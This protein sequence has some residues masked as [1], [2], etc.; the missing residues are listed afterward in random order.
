MQPTKPNLLIIGAR[1]A[2]TTLLYETLGRHPDVWFPKKKE[3][4][5]FTNKTYG[6]RRAW[7]QYLKLFET[8]PSS[9]KIVGEASTGYTTL[10]YNGPTP[11]RIRESLGQPKLIY[12][13]RDPVA[14]TVSNYRHN[15]T[16]GRYRPGTTLT[17]AVERNPI[18]IKASCYA[19]QL[20]A[21]RRIFSEHG[22]LVLLAEEL[23]ACP[24][25]VMARVEHYLQLKPY[26]KWDNDLPKVNPF[27]QLAGAFAVQR[28]LGDGWLAQIGKRIMPRALKHWLKSKVPAPSHLPEVTDADRDVVFDAIAPDLKQLF[29]LIG[30]RLYIWPSVQRLA[31]YDESIAELVSATGPEVD[32]SANYNSEKVKTN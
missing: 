13:L 16:S 19:F 4:H 18:L 8:A 5:Y 7:A 11:E 22:V 2:S 32:D 26:G 12:I 25:E 28:V 23:H 20:K 29:A 17:E 3:P 1:K 9:A 31:T 27:E 30:P 6:S 21:Y 15:Y 14:R 24:G 10:P